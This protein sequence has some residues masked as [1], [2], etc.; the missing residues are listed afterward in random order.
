MADEFSDLSKIR[1][2]QPGD[3]VSAEPTSQPT[4]AIEIRLQQLE[5]A[6]DALS[7]SNSLSQII[8]PNVP[9]QNTGDNAVVVNN[10]VY[11]DANT[12]LYEQAIAGVTFASG[13]YTSNPTALALGIC[14][15]VNGALGDI[16]IAGYAPWINT[17]QQTA[18]V[19]TLEEF[20]PGLPYYLSASQP[21]RITKFPPAIQIQVLVATDLHYVLHQVYGDPN[22]LLT[23]IKQACGMRPVGSLRLNPPDYAQLIVVGFDGLE[24]YNPDLSNPGY[25]DWQSTSQSADTNLVQYGYM[26]ADATVQAQSAEP[27]Y[28][29]VS[30]APT[31][32]AI[33][34]C[35]SATLANLSYDNSSAFNKVSGLLALLSG[36][37]GNNGVLRSY[38][39][40]DNDHTTVLGMLEFK[41]VDTDVSFQRD[42]IFK[43]PD[44]FQGWKMINAPVSPLAVAVLSSGEIASITV[45]E[46]GVGY[47]TPPIVVI[48]GDGS[49]AAA[50]AVL[51]ESGSIVAITVTNPG[52]GYTTAT[53]SFVSQ[54]S[55]IKVLNGGTD[56]AG[57]LALVAG[58]G[59]RAIGSVTLTNGG[60]GYFLPP[61]VQVVDAGGGGTG[62]GAV[63]NAVV[64]GGI[65]TELQ[66]INP[67]AGYTDPWLIIRPGGNYGYLPSSAPTLVVKGG[68]T[69]ATGLAGTLNLSPMGVDRVEVVSAG[70]SYS[71]L[72][73]AV[74]DTPPPGPGSV[75]ATCELQIDDVGHI[76]KVI[77][78]NPGG[79]Y[80]TA[81]AITIT[82]PGGFGVKALFEVYISA[83]VQ[84]VT[85]SDYGSGYTEAPKLYAGCALDHIEIDDGGS[86]FSPSFLPTIQIGP[87]DDLVAGVQATASPLLGL[88][89]A[90]VTIENPGTSYTAPGDWAIVV[91][92]GSPGVGAVTPVLVPL[93]AGGA[94]VGVEIVD[95][96]S[97]YGGVPVL[98]LTYTGGGSPSGTDAAMLAVMEASDRVVSIVLTNPGAGYINPPLVTMIPALDTQAA[99]IATAKLIGHGAILKPMMA[100]SGGIQCPQ[101]AVLAR[102]NALQVNDY[103]YDLND[104][105]SAPFT[106]PSRG[107]FYYN[108][109]ADPLLKAKYP[110]IPPEKTLFMFNGTELTVTSFN[111]LTGVPLDPDADVIMSRKSPF[112][113]TFDVNGCP[114]DSQY[115][116]YVLDKNAAGIDP[117]IAETG[118]YGFDAIWFRYWEHL[119]KYEV[120]RNR[121]WMHINRGSRFYQTGQVLSLGVL[122]P[123]RLYDV[124]TGS[125]VQSDGTPM[126]G[127]LLLTFDGQAPFLTGTTGAQLDLAQA[128]NLTVIY[129]NNTG[130]PVMISSI[131]LMVSYQ[132]NTPSITPTVADDAQITVGTANGNY[133]DIIGTIDPTL[134][135]DAGVETRLYAVGQ[136]KQIFPDANNA[137]PTINPGQQVYMRVNSPTSGNIVTQLVTARVCGF[138]F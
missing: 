73:T 6:L 41:F 114:W 59:P 1:H 20:V 123:F 56:G 74:F 5:A 129:Q 18:M 62:A 28:I 85:I 52:S 17:A 43:F 11:F 80:L 112:W 108:L 48:T 76:S 31:T 117:V 100:G 99:G 86:S 47:D 64:L 102:G 119:Y 14:V 133:R 57:T 66:L 75:T 137:A 45:Q 33:S 135:T 124:A 131:V 115:A 109:N 12:G 103:G 138:L 96:G 36:S 71:V 69:G 98:T 84:S 87:P 132:S 8:I 113:T 63:V 136:V 107:V 118:P 90:S 29:R 95:P 125:Q 82:D 89:V 54:V 126:T 134:L 72:S 26:I 24:L 30:V 25:G 97:G 106:K 21:G 116:A 92:G 61:D 40:L 104:S 122:P 42:V 130:R 101:A 67:G 79:G 83:S 39:V 37:G 44:S 38:T 94:L 23:P 34:V 13:V 2:V 49:N 70:I 53:V 91:S 111:E 16:M 65:I 68:G 81:P 127:Q 19:E 9:I 50:T 93:I 78:T 35:E 121:G 32:G 7:Q 77:V 4:R 88:Q 3:P 51:N 110:S 105:P 27:V 22:S 10:V 60:S 128:N 55:T 120:N 15:A 46:G 58:S